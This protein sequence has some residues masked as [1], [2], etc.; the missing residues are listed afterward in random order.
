M[1]K[2][3]VY[4]NFQ[5]LL[6]LLMNIDKSQFQYMVTSTKVR[7]NKTNNPYFDKVIK[8][9][10]QTTLPVVDYNQRVNSINGTTDFTSIPSTVGVHV[11]ECVIYNAKYNRY[12]FNYE[13]FGVDENNIDYIM[14]DEN[15]NR[16]DFKQFEVKRSYD[17]NKPKFNSVMVSNINEVSMNKVRYIYDK[18]LD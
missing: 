12:Y 13:F 1:N 8:R 15:I 18:N 2:Q 4:I 16:D 6:D 10:K 5:Q 3:V 11:S 9:K 17:P 14:D 7:M